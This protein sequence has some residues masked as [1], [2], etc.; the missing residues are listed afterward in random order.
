MQLRQAFLLSVLL[1]PTAA[2]TTIQVS[3]AAPAAPTIARFDHAPFD[4]DLQRHVDGRGRVDYAGLERDRADLDAY[5]ASLAQVSPDSHPD[6]FPD[7]DARLAYWVNAYNASAIVAV[8]T[9]YPI[10]S[11]KDVNPKTLFFLPRVTGF[12]LLQRITLGG[13]KTSLYELENEIVRKRFADPRIHFA[14]N[15]ASASCPRLPRRAFTA[16]AL[17]LQLEHETLFFM[18]EARNVSIDSEAGEILVSSILDWYESDFVEWMKAEHPAA[19]ATPVGYVRAHLAP[20]K[21]SE[22]DACASCKV[23]FADYDWTLNDQRLSD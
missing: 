20:E 8:L 10:D 16:E 7:D 9:H 17:Q 4:A 14:L 21:R 15:C 12:F 1:L 18:S 23:R 5:Y 3:S 6:L 19:E 2:C 13:D 11:V 22:L